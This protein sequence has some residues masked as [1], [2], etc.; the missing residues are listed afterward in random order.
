MK[1]QRSLLSSPD[2]ALFSFLSRINPVQASQSYFFKI[3]FNIIQTIC[4][5]PVYT[6]THKI[7]CIS[8]LPRIS[9]SLIWSTH[10]HLAQNTNDCIIFSSRK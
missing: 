4:L 10:L 2:P 8:L 7:V 1:P 9:S 3:H 5:F 6:H